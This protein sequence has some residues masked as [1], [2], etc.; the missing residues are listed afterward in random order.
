[1]ADRRIAAVVLVLVV[2]LCVRLWV[3]AAPAPAAAD[4]GAGPSGRALCV[5]CV[6]VGASVFVGLHDGELAGKEAAG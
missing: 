1:M 6:A 3:E 5:W 2:A 4:G